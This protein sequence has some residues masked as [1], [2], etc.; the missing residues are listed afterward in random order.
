MGFLKFPLWF[1]FIASLCLFAKSPQG[2]KVKTPSDC[3]IT[4]AMGGRPA[5]TMRIHYHLGTG[6]GLADRY[7]LLSL[8]QLF[9]KEELRKQ[10][11]GGW[12]AM[13]PAVDFNST[14]R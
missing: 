1:S 10:A 6:P 12:V 3:N 14:E 8:P 2:T 9:Q 5:P 11:P 4:L 13:E 7:T